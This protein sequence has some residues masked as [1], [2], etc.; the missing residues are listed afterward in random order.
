MKCFFAALLFVCAFLAP[1]YWTFIPAVR[2]DVHAAVA[3]LGHAPVGIFAVALITIVVI[4]F[5]TW[6]LQRTALPKGRK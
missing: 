6:M 5:D 4:G 2:A 3:W 1:E